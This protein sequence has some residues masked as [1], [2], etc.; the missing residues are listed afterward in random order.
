MRWKSQYLAQFRHTVPL[1]TKKEP[2]SAQSLHIVL[3]GK[4]HHHAHFRH[5]IALLHQTPQ[6][7]PNSAENFHTVLPSFGTSLLCCSKKTKFYRKFAHCFILSRSK[8][9]SF[10]VVVSGAGGGVGGGCGGVFYFF[11]FVFKRWQTVL[12]SMEKKKNQPM[13]SACAKNLYNIHPNVTSSGYWPGRGLG[14][15][16]QAAALWCLPATW[17][18]TKG[19]LS[20]RFFRRRERARNPSAVLPVSGEICHA[21]LLLLI[22]LFFCMCGK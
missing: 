6:K 19:P 22:F 5:A 18:S 13:S 2:N 21:R 7:G 20:L 1:L 15:A 17:N 12:F 11:V 9:F 3:R 14:T 4:S 8:M 10:V 16:F